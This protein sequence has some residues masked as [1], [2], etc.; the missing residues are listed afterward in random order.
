MT[1]TTGF[2]FYEKKRTFVVEKLNI[3]DSHLPR[4]KI[5]GDRKIL[6]HGLR[7]SF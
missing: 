2:C 7:R 6:K 4:R 1:Y 5:K 3:L